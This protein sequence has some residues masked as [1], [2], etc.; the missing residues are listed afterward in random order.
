MTDLRIQ[1]ISSLDRPELEPYRSLKR[2]AEHAK[3]GIFVVE[4]DKVLHRLLDSDFTIVSVLLLA[5]RLAEFE[6]QLRARP[7]KEIAVF[8]CDKPVLAELVGFEIY[9]GVLAIAKIPPPLSLEKILAGSPHPRFFVAM[10]GL[11]NAE[12]V[13]ALMRNCVA[14][15]VQ[16]LLAGETCSSPFLRRTVR[17]SMGAIFKLPVLDLTSTGRADLPV[18]QDAQQRVPTNKQTLVETLHKLRA[19]GIRCVAAHPRPDGKILSRADFSG[20]C[21]LVFGSE[22]HGIS[23]AVLAACDEAVAIPMANEVDSLNV[24]AA[25]AVFLYEVNR[26]RGKT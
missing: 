19:N 15:G 6:P 14:F 1:Q 22:G 8:V 24:S 2:S 10:D 16:A 23:P 12:N 17:N 7:E 3:L 11:A 20:D 21:C 18:S 13:G 26:Q 4:G 9:Q 5:E 25:A